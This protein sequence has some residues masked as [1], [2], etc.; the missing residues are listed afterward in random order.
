M[1]STSR[2]L[3]R[4]GARCEPVSLKEACDCV[5]HHSNRPLREIAERIGRTESTLGKECSLYDEE[6][7]LPLRLVVPLT[8]AADNDALISYL[9]Q[10]VGGVFVRLHADVGRGLDQEHV[11]H[12]VAAFG[13]L[14]QRYGSSL[15]DG[16]ITTDEADHFEAGGAAACQA[17]VELQLY[18]RARAAQQAA[19]TRRPA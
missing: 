5:G 13:E 17:I 11:A 8:I 15:A 4:S 14:L 9:A 18:V 7:C 12:A 3:C 16:T 1:S 10:A 2:K 6:H 19:A